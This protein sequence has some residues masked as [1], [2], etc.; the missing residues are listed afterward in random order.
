[1]D[2]KEYVKNNKRLVITLM[3]VVSIILGI[4]LLKKVTIYLPY[5]IQEKG[6]SND[7]P[8]WFDPYGVAGVGLLVCIFVVWILNWSFMKFVLK[9]LD[10]E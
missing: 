6:W 4:I 1:M 2:I 8:T 7:L 9:E 5:L 10:E 3:I